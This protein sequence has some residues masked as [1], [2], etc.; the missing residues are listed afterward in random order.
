MSD[1]ITHITLWKTACEHIKLTLHTDAF[2]K[3][4]AII[5]PVS[6]EQGALTL[7]VDNDF[8]QKWIED[9][10]LSL[11]VDALRAAG[12]PQDI[13]VRFT[14]S[15]SHPA[16]VSASQAAADRRHAH[17][18]AAP[19]PARGRKRIGT[20]LSACNTFDTFVVGPC[21]NFAYSAAQA[22]AK[23]PGM[24]YNPLYIYAETAMGKTHLM[25]AVGH[26]VA[27]ANPDLVVAYVSAET[28]LNEYIEE[29]ILQ[30]KGTE[31][32]NRYR[33]VDVFLVDDIH[34]LGKSETLQEEFFHT[35][36]MLH[37][38]RKQIILCSDRPAKDIQK[39]ES[40]LVSRFE[41]GLV[42]SMERPEFE[43]RMAI[44]RAKQQQASVKLSDDL[45]TFI[46]QNVTTNVR[47]L[48]GALIRAISYASLTGK[49]HTLD[50]LRTL[51]RDLLDQEVRPDIT[52]DTIQKAVAEEFDIRLADMGSKRRPASVAV[53]R[54][55]AMFLTRRLTRASL[56]EI[57]THFGK[58]HATVLHACKAVANRMDV[59]A[60][61]SKR[62]H[63]AVRT[64]G[65]NPSVLSPAPEQ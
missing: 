3:W 15:E 9:N 37:N 34:F 59:D 23:S 64:L 17:A 33:N 61:F 6:L 36:N 7:S 24:A 31:F 60:D 57:G 21:N 62:I 56:P 20:A 18:A 11:I 42:T 32:R 4:F 28:L 19:K 29:V 55:V 44:L 30:R 12:A 43:T 5:S 10:Y 45:L 47:R 25:H 40:R 38:A 27:K 2:N 26:E 39:L 14:V 48:E 52:V 41:W 51:L 54:Q 63:N 13:A 49:E 1:S 16:P 22:V 35:F 46:A 65:R 53:P 50:S 58:T 8:C